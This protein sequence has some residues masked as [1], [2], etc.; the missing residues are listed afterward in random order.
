MT[1]M[2]EPSQRR[3]YIR[4]EPQQRL[5]LALCQVPVSVLDSLSNT[6]NMRCYI[7]TSILSFLFFS[8]FL[9]C[10]LAQV[11]RDDSPIWVQG[12]FEDA[13]V[14][15]ND[16]SYNAG[17]TITV[18]G[19]VLNIPR[20]LL[21]QFPAA[22]VPWRDFVASKSD[23]IGFETLVMG[24]TIEGDPRVG[25]VVIT[26]FFE[27]LSFGFIESL[28]Y[29]DGSMKIENGPTVR[30]SD[31][32]GVFSVG[33]D[34]ASF[35]TADDQS[36]SITAFS[37]FPMC[38]PRN[39][40]DPLCPLSNRPT[41]R[42]GIFRAPDPLVMAPFLP[43][44]LITFSGFRRGDEVIAF[45]IVA[46]NVQI[47]TGDDIVY[48][49]M[50][51]ALLGI[52]SPSPAAEIAD[53]RFIG[54]SS[55]PRTSVTL[56]ALDVNPCTGETTER[57]IAGVGLRGGR[58]FQNKFEYRNEILFGYTREYRAVAE[59]DGV[60]ITRRTRNGILAGSYIQPVNVWVQ[61]EMDIP[62]LFANGVPFEFREMEFLTK[63]VG[64]DEN[65]NVW[66]P[67]DPFPQSLV[68][69]SAP[70]CGGVNSRIQRRRTFG[71]RFGRMKAEAVAGADN[72]GTEEPEVVVAPAEIAA[73]EEK[74]EL[75]AVLEQDQIE[76]L[77][78]D[79]PQL[80]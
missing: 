21:V 28:N 48:I 54:F 71:S 62:G 55:N 53:S 24:N 58:N 2:T 40:S 65:G 5:V 19:F 31:P 74:A 66:G 67:L 29:T 23:F 38:I 11:L 45:S 79:G 36:P 47:T 37:G 33:Y 52:F 49:R 50:E 25:Q 51:L 78:G 3:A 35:M 75:D 15:A 80:Q 30:I 17:G 73:I 63:G 6:V 8:L 1:V 18:N 12:A 61:T 9:P 32:N 4:H 59:I 27:G 57:M 76:S 56:Y 10:V 7:F 70:N 60:P 20:N 68:P 77:F 39:G 26:E 64:R 69:I 44:D 72:K 14:T 16:T 13:T 22:W 43:G 42:P 41:G 34:G 46:Q